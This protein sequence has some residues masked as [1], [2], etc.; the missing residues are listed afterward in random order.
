MNKLLVSPQLK[1][2]LGNFL[3]QIAASYYASK[4]Y[5][6]Q[7]EIDISDISVIH[8]PIES[9]YNNI[10]RK[11]KFINQYYD[12]T[13][14]EPFQPI[15]FSEIPNPHNNLKLK[16]YYQNEKYLNEFSDEIL[17]LFEVDLET[18]RYLQSKYSDILKNN[19][20]SL[21]VRRGN[22]VEKS[23]FHPLQSVE[24]YKQ[25]ISVIGDDLHYLIFSDDINWCKENLNF[26]KNKTYIMDNMDY[27][28]LYL[29]SMC[30][31]NIIANS[32]FS[33]WGAWLNKNYNKKVIYPSN[34]FGVSF[35]DTSEIGCKNWIKI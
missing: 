2:G 10:F 6:R 12:Y 31:N 1:G 16:G 34:W 33:W 11:L 4:K 8:S 20:C 18:L 24:Y 7:L 22:Y 3:F 25:S 27:Q 17:D 15:Q 32:S 28:D 19:T 21:H 9:Y 5:N 35:L 14:D 13:V 29:M 26:I 23:D 30:D